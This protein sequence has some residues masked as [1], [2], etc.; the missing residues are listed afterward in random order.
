LGL[1]IELDTEYPLTLSGLFNDGTTH[2]E[3]EDCIV[4][5][6]KGKKD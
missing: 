3:G 6:K 5:V 2:I 4:F 1:V